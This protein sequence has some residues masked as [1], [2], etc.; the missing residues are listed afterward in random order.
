VKPRLTVEELDLAA[1]GYLFGDSIAQI[2]AAHTPPISRTTLWGRLGII[3]HETALPIGRLSTQQACQRWLATTR[4]A[5][6]RARM[7]GLP[8]PH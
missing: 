5:S 7:Y 1:Q 2:A 8:D 4:Y 6:H 3:R